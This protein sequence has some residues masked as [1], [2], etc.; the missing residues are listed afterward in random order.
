[1][2]TAGREAGAGRVI[3]VGPFRSDVDDVVWVH[4]ER[5]GPVTALRRGLA[6]VSAAWVA[7]L[8]ADLPFLRARHVSELLNRASDGNGA[9][10][11]DD[12]GREQWLAG[13]WRAAALKG[14]LAAYTGNSLH[15]LLSPLDPEL[16][17]FEPEPGEPPPWLDCDTPAD[18][19]HARRLAAGRAPG[20]QP[21]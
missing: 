7:V 2:V 9:L 11:V 21:I 14:A 13:C 18:V 10:L 6:E 15:G 3:V 1:V 17:R 20:H 12:T 16:V 4:D 8:A 19:E 5:R